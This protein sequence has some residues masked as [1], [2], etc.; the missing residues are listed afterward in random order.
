MRFFAVKLSVDLGFE[1]KSDFSGTTNICCR[2]GGLE[3]VTT[4][5]TVDLVK[6][7]GETDR[8]DAL[9]HVDVDP[10]S[11]W[12]G[13]WGL[14]GARGRTIPVLVLSAGEEKEGIH[15][16]DNLLHASFRA[17]VD[18]TRPSLQHEKVLELG[19]DITAY[20]RKSGTSGRHPAIVEFSFYDDEGEHSSDGLNCF[21]G[22]M[23][24]GVTWDEYRIIRPSD[25]SDLRQQDISMLLRSESSDELYWSI[26]R[27]AFDVAHKAVRLQTSS[28]EYRGALVQCV[29]SVQTAIEMCWYKS[30][31][32]PHTAQYSWGRAI[33]PS[34]GGGGGE[35]IGDEEMQK[36]LHTILLTRNVIAHRGP[37][38][39]KEHVDSEGREDRMARGGSR[40]LT[41]EDCLEFVEHCHDALV[42]LEER[43]SCSS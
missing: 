13:A 28:L 3:G 32:L 1:I 15:M 16:A 39:F 31:G 22:T 27:S 38:M 41:Y 12:E 24:Y 30:Y 20:V 6:S 42:W 9:Y 34:A 14:G 11:N 21:C 10:D 7:L 19:R 40:E 5:I 35:A 25:L 18:V 29:M 33:C 8:L 23:P 2:P 26:W 37:L 17:L 43:L 36:N 4:S